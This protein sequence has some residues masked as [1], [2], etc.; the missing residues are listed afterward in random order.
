MANNKKAN[1]KMIVTE[2][3][4]NQPLSPHTTAVL[5]VDVQQNEMQ[6]ALHAKYPEYAEALSTSALPNT[7]RLVEGARAAGCEIIYTVIEALTKDGR[8]VGL[9][10][11]LSDIF[12]PKNSPLAKV[13]PEACPAPD[14]IIVPKTSSGVFNTTNIAY[15]LRNMGISKVIVAGLLTDQCVD[16]AIRDGAD[17][18]FYMVCAHD[19]CASRT[20]ARHEQALKAFSGYCR[21]QSVD[22]IL[23]DIR[24]ASSE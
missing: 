6:P 10:H 9:D 11:K 24:A 22:E 3:K 21:V 12:I 5:I 15:L 19:A 20:F 23:Q 7:T 17:I 2:A 4:R 1:P 16:M 14:D 8:D 13:L 18:G